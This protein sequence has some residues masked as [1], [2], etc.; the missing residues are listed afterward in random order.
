[1]RICC[2][3]LKPKNPPLIHKTKSLYYLALKNEA[4]KNEK[5]PYSLDGSTKHP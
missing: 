2:L 3:P 1:M 5:N 4:N